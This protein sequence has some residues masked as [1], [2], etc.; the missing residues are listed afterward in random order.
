M[1]VKRVKLRQITRGGDR[2]DGSSHQQLE[3]RVRT[4]SLNTTQTEILRHPD[5][6]QK[7]PGSAVIIFAD[8]GQRNGSQGAAFVSADH[9]AAGAVF[10]QY[11]PAGWFQ[12]IAIVSG[13]ITWQEVF[14]FSPSGIPVRSREIETLGDYDYLV[15]VN[16]DTKLESDQAQEDSENENAVVEGGIRGYTEDVPVFTDFDGRPIVNRAGDL[17]EGVTRKQRR[18]ACTVTTYWKYP[19]WEIFTLLNGTVN[20]GTVTIHGYDFPAGTCL[21][22]DPQMAKSPDE[23]E[24]RGKLWPV[25]YEIL[26]NMDGWISILPNRGYNALEYQARFV[27]ESNTDPDKIKYTPWKTLDYAEWDASTTTEKR[28][29][30]VRI[31]EDTDAEVADSTWLDNHGQKVTATLD[32][33]TV[34]LVATAANAVLTYPGSGTQLQ[35]TDAGKF[36]VI[37]GAGLGGRQLKTRIESVDGSGN[38]TLHT[39]PQISGTLNARIGGAWSNVFQV[40][41]LA[42]WSSLPMPN[43][44]R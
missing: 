41:D 34:S 42:D 33:Q 40:E 20:S 5:I 2:S 9:V 16:C 22:N 17:Y 8:A 3:Y 19:P 24:G 28:V 18:L 15:R 11:N 43:N 23:F 4:D 7:H 32:F 26:I 39:A 29:L 10:G 30:K 13:V 38:A 36:I 14:V 31:T 27:T 35:A 1:A 37:N 21:L 25:D 44:N 12:P 6:P